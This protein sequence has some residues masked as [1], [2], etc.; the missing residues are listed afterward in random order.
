LT[1]AV[2]VIFVAIVLWPWA[3]RTRVSPRLES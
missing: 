1:F 2:F 3:H